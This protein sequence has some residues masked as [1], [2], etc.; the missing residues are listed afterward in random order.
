M[1]LVFLFGFFKLFGQVTF[2]VSMQFWAAFV[3]A[4]IL[5]NEV[6][7]EFAACKNEGC[8]QYFKCYLDLQNCPIFLLSLFDSDVILDFRKCGDGY[9]KNA[10]LRNTKSPRQ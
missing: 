4:I 6:F 5:H 3:Y 10:D 2:T 9:H 1:F 7:A 8:R